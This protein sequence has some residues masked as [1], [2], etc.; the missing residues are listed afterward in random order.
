[1]AYEAEI[2]AEIDADPLTRGYAGMSD[3]AVAADINTAYRERNRTSMSGDEI[4]N[5]AVPA[6]YNALTDAQKDQFLS[7]CGRDSI[8]PFAANN[9]GLITNIFGGGSGTVTALQTVR[10]ESISR[11]IELGIGTVKE[12][13][14]QR[15]RAL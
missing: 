9:V 13:Q 6:D 2:K 11:G 1:M 15:A 7:F 10:V 3:A 5:A 4:F 12:G 8:D 14:V